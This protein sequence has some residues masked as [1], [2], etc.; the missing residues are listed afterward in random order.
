MVL[1]PGAPGHLR[2]AQA[3]TEATGRLCFVRAA[4]FG[5]QNPHPVRIRGEHDG[6]ARTLVE[7]KGKKQI[8]VSVALGS[9][10]LEARS[11]SPEARK[12]SNPDECRSPP[13]V[14]EVTKI[15]TAPISV[16]ALGRGATTI[17]GWD[18]R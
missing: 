10:S 13:L 12:P 2:E 17:C 8:C 5:V 11:A 9:W 7:L 16:S 15:P 4:D 3:A 18:L 6:H 14:V 1:G